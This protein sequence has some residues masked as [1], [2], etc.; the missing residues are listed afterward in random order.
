MRCTTKTEMV[1]DHT[2]IVR[3]H[4][5]VALP[6]FCVAEPSIAGRPEDSQKLMRNFMGDDLDD[7]LLEPVDVR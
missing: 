7:S 1:D 4:D 2:V 6:L 5:I 3:V